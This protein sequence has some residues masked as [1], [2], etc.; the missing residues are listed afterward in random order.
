MLGT[1]TETVT[2][3]VTVSSSLTLH[4]MAE[5]VRATTVGTPA[6]LVGEDSISKLS[7]AHVVLEW[8]V[9]VEGNVVEAEV[10]DRGIGHSVG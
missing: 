10:P 8:G 5:T 2:V 6:S 1:I 7:T 3:H 4:S 9:A